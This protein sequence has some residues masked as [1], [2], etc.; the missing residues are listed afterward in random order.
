MADNVY[1]FIV[2]YTDFIVPLFLFLH[3]QLVNM[4]N[5]FTDLFIKHEIIVVVLIV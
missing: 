3:F 4:V 5:P 1:D 2:K